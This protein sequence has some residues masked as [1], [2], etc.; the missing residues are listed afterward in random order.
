MSETLE[1]K[2]RR[3]TLLG[4]EKTNAHFRAINEQF[5]NHLSDSGFKSNCYPDKRKSIEKLGTYKIDVPQMMSFVGGAF[6]VQL[7]KNQTTP[8]RNEPLISLHTMQPNF[9]CVHDST[10]TIERISLFNLTFKLQN[11]KIWEQTA[12]E[13][14]DVIFDTHQGELDETGI[15]PA[16]FEFQRTTNRN[17]NKNDIK[18][19]CN[20]R[21]PIQI[22]LTPTSVDNLFAF[23]ETMEDVFYKHNKINIQSNERPIHHFNN[24]KDLRKLI[25]EPNSIE[26]NM[27]KVSINLMTSMDRVVSL[28]LF[29]WCNKIDVRERI[30]QIT[31][32][33]AIDTL[34]LNTQNSML[35]NPTSMAFECTL[36]QEKWSKRLVIATNFT[37]NVIHLQINPNDFWTFAKVQLDFWSCINRRFSTPDEDD[38]QKQNSNIDVSQIDQ[39][40]LKPYELPRITT[41]KSRANEEYFQDDLR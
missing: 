31:Y 28:S 10:E 17:E 11:Q 9:Y 6:I 3:Q 38:R 22:K 16:L 37:S 35:L 15:S 7:Y 5:E 24:I 40:N 12:I 23:H 1:T 19:L 33:T 36:S 27:T 13:F 30:K 32:T 20:V 29:K 26:F 4:Q 34:S 2:S 39:E 21:K 8:A 41:S 18:I 14:G 25:G